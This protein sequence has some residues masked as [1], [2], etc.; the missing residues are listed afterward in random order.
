MKRKIVS[1]MLILVF[2]ISLISI[3]ACQTTSTTSSTTTS[4]TAATLP[5][6]LDKNEKATL[7]FLHK[8][9][10]PERIPY[11]NNVVATFKQEYPNITIQMEAV[12][13]EPMK[14]KLRVMLGGNDVPDVFFSWGGEFLSKFVR[15]G[16][17]KDISAYM[18]ADKTWT[19]SFIS[20]LLK[21]GVRDE[22]QYGIPVRVS[23]KFFIYNTEIFAK[24]NLKAPTTWNEF[25]Q[26]CETLKKNGEIPILLGNQAPWTAAHYMTTFNQKMVDAKVLASDYNP[27]TGVFSDPGYIKAL[28][29]LQDLNTKGYF[30]SAVNSTQNQQTREMFFTGKGAII[31]DEMPNFQLR[32]E[33]NIP[34]KWDFFVCPTPPDAK[35]NQNVITGA[36]DF[37]MVSKSSKNPAAAVA[38]LKFITNQTN[39]AQMCKELG[40]QPCVKGAVNASNSLPQTI[41]AMDLIAK[42]DGLAEWLDTATEASVADKYLANLQE[43]FNGKSAE[44][45][46]KEVQTEAKRI[47]TEM[48]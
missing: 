10:E 14:E 35:G 17:V 40:F 5:A 12:A 25:M 13:D 47:A 45:I 38:F 27:K 2:S 41:K 19:D 6:A 30:N 28:T 34:G 23:A 36:P 3:S 42:A 26:V 48:K 21:S 22:K 18:Q 33:K 15:S 46:M 32:Y 31:Y 16:A 43:L 39:T 8:W 1:I 29:L 44:S 7:K 9:P 24:Y 11:W 37:L 20:T 4:A